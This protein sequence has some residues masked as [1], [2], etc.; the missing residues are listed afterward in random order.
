MG[1]GMPT[2][3]RNCL[4]V[5]SWS[6]VSCAA[7][8]FEHTKVLP[9]G[10]RNITIKS[11]RTVIEEKSN[12]QGRLE[13]I[14]KPLEKDLTLNKILQSKTGLKKTQLHALILSENLKESDS[15]GTFKA[16]MIGSVA[17]TA[18]VFSYGL[19]DRLT[20]AM[21]VPYYSANVKVGSSFQINDPVAMALVASLVD[22][23]QIKEANELVYK[24]NNAVGELNK[25]LVKNNFSEL[26]DWSDSGVGDITLAA[27]LKLV[28]YK[29]FHLATTN[30]MVLPTGKTKSPFVLNDIPFGK[31][32]YS[33]YANVGVDEYI[34]SNVFLNQY[35]KYTH[36]LTG[37][38]KV[39]LATDKEAIEV[40]V[41]EVDY[42]LGDHLDSGVSIQYEPDSGLIAA[43][44]YVYGKQ[45]G[46][47]YEIVNEAVRQKLED[48]TQKRAEYIEFKVGYSSV[49]AF[50][51]GEALAPLTASLEF[52]KHQ[53]SINT[54]SNDFMTFDV[55]LFF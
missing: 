9:K 30:G 54:P 53:A 49:K 37:S 7:F 4:I 3:M 38:K 5:I 52:K 35:V 55:A 6:F 22:K 31:G 13:S 50:K 45:Y 48:N 14:A 51:R 10:V 41:E 16:D 1:T 28:E 46:D 18:P 8:A 24:L 11:V 47:T 25:K 19:T 36:H 21:A 29:W 27:K 42:R 44:G 17:V 12:H 32:A 15:L 34:S 43:L 26:R 40:E 23:N 33:L 39:R 2:L 20:L